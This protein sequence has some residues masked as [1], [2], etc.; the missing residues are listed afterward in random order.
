MVNSLVAHLASTHPG[1]H[2]IMECVNEADLTGE[3]ANDAG[4]ALGSM[5]D[6]VTY[7]TALKNAAHAADANIIVLGPSGSSIN[8]SNVHLYSD[9]N[10]FA[11]QP[12]AA[13]S[14]DAMNF[15]A[16]LQSCSVYCTVPELLETSWGQVTN[17]IKPGG[18]LA[19]K[20]VWITEANWGG[21]PP[22]NNANLT[23][24]QKRQYLARTVMYAF[25]N[26]VTS[27]HW[28]AY[29]SHPDNLSAG[30]GSLI[31][32]S[33]PTSATP[34]QAAVTMGTME[35]WLVGSTYFPSPCFQD[36]HGT[37]TCNI[38]SSPASTGKAQIVW[39]GTT[40]ETIT[41]SSTYTKV[42]NWDG[43]NTPIVSHQIVAGPDVVMA[44]P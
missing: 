37:W 39:N 20:P 31:E 10:N 3:W 28:Y 11:G 23:A 16:Y 6:L 19:N 40:T 13:A 42:L 12:G 14:M 8:T 1:V 29:D 2:W 21:S 22:A 43:S 4:T 35:N 17:L 9:G 7:C 26:N 30:F 34:N 24:A 27:L 15:H 44:V 41:L 36:P 32:G 25:L 5:T 18:L 33:P 38:I